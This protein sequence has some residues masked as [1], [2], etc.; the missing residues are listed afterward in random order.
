MLE[1]PA[2]ADSAVMW[3]EVLLA[4]LCTHPRIVPVY[5]VSLQVPLLCCR[6]PK[7]A[8]VDVPCLPAGDIPACSPAYEMLV[9]LLAVLLPGGQ[10]PACLPACR[11]SCS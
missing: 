4:R 7:A 10:L 8:V 3:H 11:S 9:V 2:G 5:G 6:P 1:L